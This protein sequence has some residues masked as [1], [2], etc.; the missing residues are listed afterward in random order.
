[1]KQASFANEACFIVQRKYFY[2][3]MKVLSFFQQFYYILFLKNR[4]PKTVAGFGIQL[5]Q[6]L[7]DGLHIRTAGS[8]FVRTQR[9]LLSEMQLFCYLTDIRLMHQ[10]K[11]AD[12]GERIMF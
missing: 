1:M 6:L 3:N 5:L 4:S 10:T 8:L 2:V 11:G 7:E 9:L 12:D